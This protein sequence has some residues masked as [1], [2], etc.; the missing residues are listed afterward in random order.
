MALDLIDLKRLAGDVAKEE[1]P[2][3]EILG[4]T[5]AEGGRNYAEVI[6]AHHRDSDRHRLVIGVKRDAPELVVRGILRDR[7]REHLQEFE[8]T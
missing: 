4:A 3:L 5:S 8:P 7:M 1:N 2:A 6:V